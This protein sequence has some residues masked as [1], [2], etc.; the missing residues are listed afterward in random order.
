MIEGADLV[1]TVCGHADE[2]CPALPPGVRRLHWPLAD[3]AKAAGNPEERL[4]VF[5]NSRDEIRD[6]VRQ[7]LESLPARR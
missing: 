4:A 3:P 1:V 5:R 6:R 7:L 2:H